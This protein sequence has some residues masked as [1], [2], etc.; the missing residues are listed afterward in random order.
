ML[1][2]FF[3]TNSN[4]SSVEINET[5]DNL[6]IKGKPDCQISDFTFKLFDE[7]K[8]ISGRDKFE[9]FLDICGNHVSVSNTSRQSYDLLSEHINDNDDED[10]FD[11]DL[12]ITKSKNDSE[13]SI[14][15][16]ERFAKY[17]SKEKPL[18]L[19]TTF[20][21]K[22]ENKIVFEVFSTINAF[23]SNGILFYQSG[24]YPDSFKELLPKKRQANLQMFH[25]N[26]A[27]GNID[28]KVL[29]SDF[30]LL[31]DS[32]IGEINSLFDKISGAL[33]LIFIANFSEFNADNSLSYKIN[34]YKTIYCEGNTLDK[35]SSANDLLHKIYA[36]TYEGGNS[37]DK[38][39]LVRNVLSIHLNE[40]GNIKFDNEAWE[41]IRSNYQVYLKDNLQSYLEVKNK[42]GEFIIDAT[43]K[44]YNMADD[45]LESLKNNV[46]VLLTFL[47]TVVLVNGL[48]DNG[49]QTVFSD[50][51]FAI[52]L[53]LSLISALW[54]TMSYKE[55]IK[56]FESASSTIKD[57][58]I[59]N[60]DKIIME[61]EI[62]DIVDPVI[63]KNKVYL[64]GQLKRYASWWVGLLV[65]LILSFGIAN[66][67]F[68][69]DKMIAPTNTKSPKAKVTPQKVVSP[70]KPPQK[71]KAVTPTSP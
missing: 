57:I 23:Y 22:L 14:Y 69:A 50:G 60:Y 58:L 7:L 32:D 67:V 53:I 15:F 31:V 17:L 10:T 55:T 41:A 30:Y 3:K 65:C 63:T 9:L 47:L 48:K 4:V 18:N 43:A 12:K 34:G 45:L 70:V 26:S 20:S 37:V 1:A 6:T 51:Y 8:T 11:I 44:T 59:L 62:N 21:K 25:E 66:K 40:D 28:L 16:L 24:H 27:L 54:L 61:S 71:N 33:S 46:L 36:W 68:E 5:L 19:I 64:T 52:V 35:L 39:G 13:I 49:Y 29:P 42:I 56:R 38:L 2:E